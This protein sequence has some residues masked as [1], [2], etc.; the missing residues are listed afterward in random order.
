MGRPRKVF[1]N[2]RVVVP[3]D[4]G[5]WESLREAAR[6]EDTSVT[7]LARSL[8]QSFLCEPA[9]HLVYMDPLVFENVANPGSYTPARREC[10]GWLESADMNHVRI[11]WDRA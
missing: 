2:F 4:R 7:G 3:V 6:K 11:V 9:Y 10:L 8:F 1:S 5:L